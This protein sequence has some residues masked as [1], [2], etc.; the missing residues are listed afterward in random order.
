MPGQQAA[1]DDRSAEEGNCLEDDHADLTNADRTGPHEARHHCED[2]QPEHVVDHR[3]AEHDPRLGHAEPAEIA[4]D[5]AGD[6]YGGRGQRRAEEEVGVVGLPRQQC[7]PDHIGTEREGDGDADD[8]NQR[9]AQADLTRSS[10][11]VSSPI[12]SSSTMT[13]SSA[14]K[15]TIGPPQRDRSSGI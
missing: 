2:D 9:R 1:D 15:A 13:P 14:R 3:C 6:A 8:T 7:R 5:A 10:R 12:C 11:R 4:E